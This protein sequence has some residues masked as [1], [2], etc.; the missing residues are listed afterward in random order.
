MA[1]YSE[2]QTI[3]LF[4]TYKKK[5]GVL[6][7]FLGPAPF[8]YKKLVLCLGLTRVLKCLNY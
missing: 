8:S 4:Q 6:R 5:C 7:V 1:K 2:R 3:Q